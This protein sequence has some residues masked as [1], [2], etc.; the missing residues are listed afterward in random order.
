M[1]SPDDG[2]RHGMPRPGYG[3]G[4]AMVLVAGLCLSLG[5]VLL[6]VMDA[7]SGWQVMFY[8]SMAF[9]LTVFLFVAWRHRGRVAAPFRAIGWSGVVVG[10]LSGAGS[11]AYI[12]AL[13][14][15]T[16]ANTMFI[17]SVTPLFTALLAWMVIGERPRTATWL[18]IAVA[19]AGIAVMF[20]QGATE[21]RLLGSTLA[22]AAALG[23][24]AMI[25]V[26]RRARDV[27]MVPALC[28]GGLIAAAVAALM[29]GSF[30]VPAA[31][32]G[33]LMVL[34]VVQIGAGFILITLGARHVP[35]AQVSLLALSEIVLAPLWVW[36]AVDEAP[37][38]VTLAGGILVIAAVAGQA[39]AGL[40]HERGQKIL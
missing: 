19:A 3:R 30:A 38:A 11:I 22:F 27:D 25:V 17:V 12:F 2:A 20:S 7:A 33:R 15:T 8:R 31:D 26:I 21:A 39:V 4:V 35:A 6:R 29:V 40:R 10:V 9:A 32:F 28:L 13:L 37:A 14:T 18:A 34:G 23:M 36:L 5:G 1:S 24:A 16:V